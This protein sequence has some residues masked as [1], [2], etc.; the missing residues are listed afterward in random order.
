MSLVR[1]GQDSSDIYMYE[2]GDGICC[3]GC[4]LI[5]P[6]PEFTSS[7]ECVAHLVD[8]EKAGHIVPTWLVEEVIHRF[9]IF[10]CGE[11]VIGLDDFGGAF[12]PRSPD[13]KRDQ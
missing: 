10:P 9:T 7:T 6:S 12:H 11:A 2:N 8:H 5:V 1:F 4:A 3:H 13:G